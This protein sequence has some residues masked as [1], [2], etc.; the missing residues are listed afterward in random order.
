[1]SEKTFNCY[2]CTHRRPCAG[3][4]HSRCKHP[5]LPEQTNDPMIE[6]MAIFASVGRAP[7]MAVSTKELNIVGDKHGIEKGWFNFPWNFDPRWLKNCDGFE[8]RE[9]EE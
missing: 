8:P 4:A 3:S 5:S 2:E 7:K 9:K 6:L 1:M